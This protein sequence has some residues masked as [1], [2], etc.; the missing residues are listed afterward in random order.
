LETQTN[1][2]K[3]PRNEED[4]VTLIDTLGGT[5]ESFKNKTFY[6]LKKCHVVSFNNAILL[7]I[8]FKNQ[9]ASE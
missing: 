3:R 5:E 9:R 4:M 8:Y 7:V 1:L 6:G 2:T